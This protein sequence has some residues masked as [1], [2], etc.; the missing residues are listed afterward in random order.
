MNLTEVKDR[1][2]KFKEIYNKSYSKGWIYIDRKECEKLF[3]T[4]SPWLADTALELIEA[5]ERL[6][7]LHSQCPPDKVY[8]KIGVCHSTK[9]RNCFKCRLEWAF[10]KNGGK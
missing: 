6:T 4:E 1:I 8:P 7:K 9:N 3:K 5:V 2:E 10:N